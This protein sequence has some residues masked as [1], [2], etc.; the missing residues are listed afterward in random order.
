MSNIS[1]VLILLKQTYVHFSARRALIGVDITTKMTESSLKRLKTQNLK[2]TPKISE[3]LWLIPGVTMM[4]SDYWERWSWKE[5]IA[6]ALAIF[7]P[8]LPTI[9]PLRTL[10]KIT[11][12]FPKV[13]KN[14]QI[15]PNF[16]YNQ[17]NIS[18]DSKDHPKTSE[19]YLRTV[20]YVSEDSEDDR[21]S[22]EDHRKIYKVRQIQIHRLFIDLNI[23]SFFFSMFIELNIFNFFFSNVVA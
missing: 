15:L 1:L 6:T 5:N 9:T 8:L 14:S 4:G 21:R 12:T 18:E 7:F 16:T 13:T 20:E 11:R 2:N 3:E 22:L 10:P 17:P 19:P 23:F